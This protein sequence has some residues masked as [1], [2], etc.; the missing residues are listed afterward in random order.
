M[1]KANTDDGGRRGAE[2]ARRARPER[3]GPNRSTMSGRGSEGGD[4]RGSPPP[5]DEPFPEVTEVVA[6]AVRLGYRVVEENLRQ[7]RMAADRIRARDYDV[8]DA[9]D[10]VVT[11][12][13]RFVELARDLGSSWFDL[14]EAVFDDP[15]L[16][17]A[18]RPKQSELK[19]RRREEPADGA[20][21]AQKI[22]VEVI[23]HVDAIG[24]AML[25][26]LSDLQRAPQVTPLRLVDGPPRAPAI[27]GARLGSGNETGAFAVI[28]PVPPDQASGTYAGTIHET[29]SKRLLGSVSLTVP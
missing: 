10:D 8:G 3:S 5:V 18:V 19:P 25:A 12:G 16:L 7:G 6:E 23:G 21:P 1:T 4:D 22:P 11:L 14:V 27:V 24:E 29:G 13:R 17:D 9:R 15:R 26:D 2:R 28:V 20:P